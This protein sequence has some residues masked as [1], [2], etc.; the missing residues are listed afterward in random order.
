MLIA[1]QDDSAISA[2]AKEIIMINSL[3]E[4]NTMAADKASRAL[5]KLTGKPICLS[6]S[7]PRIKKM[8]ELSPIIAPEEI[9]A[10]IY[11]PLTGAVNGATMLVIPK[12]AS[13]ILVDLLMKREPGTTRKLSELDISALKEVGNI[14]SGNYLTVF[15]DQLQIKITEHIPQFSF[16]MFG[17]IVS[18]VQ[19]KLAMEIEKGVCIEIEFFIESLT[20][21]ANFL[22]LFRGEDNNT[23]QASLNSDSTNNGQ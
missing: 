1:S 2:A 21:S 17:A 10:T 22:L 5:S 3:S 6:I 11:L 13:F 8:N 12:E 16:G 14:L 19:A 23:I 9:V 18:Q 4:I 20:I 7:N 15:S